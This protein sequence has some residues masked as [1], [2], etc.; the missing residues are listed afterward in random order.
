MEES[1]KSRCGRWN[2]RGQRL[3]MLVGQRR[4]HGVEC[5]SEEDATYE[6]TMLKV[7]R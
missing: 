6:R 5:W 4:G 7:V 1:S 3:A 2:K